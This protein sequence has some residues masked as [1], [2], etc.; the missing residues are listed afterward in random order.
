[1]CVYVYIYAHTYVYIKDLLS[2]IGLL[3][4]ALR[5]QSVLDPSCNGVAE[6]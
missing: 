2:D 1:M 4:G 6:C 3:E 5:L